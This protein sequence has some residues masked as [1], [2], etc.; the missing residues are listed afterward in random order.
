MIKEVISTLAL[1]IMPISVPVIAGV[2]L[3]RFMGMEIKALLTVVLYVLAPAMVFANLSTVQITFTEL[4]RVAM[5][6]AINATLMWAISFAAGKIL[7]LPD[8]GRA[9]LSLIATL[10]NA[11]NYG[12][13]LVQLAY[14]QA[15]LEKAAVLVVFMLIFTN[16]M[17]VY[18]A[19]RSNFSVRQ[20]IVAIFKL[21]AIYAVFLA[22]LLRFTGLSLPSGLNKG[23]NMLAGA[24]S[25]IMLTVLGAQMARVKNKALGGDRQLM[26]YSGLG[27]RML[28]SPV[29]AF[30]VLN[31]LRVE[32]ILFPVLLILAS[33]P[34]AVN[35]GVLAEN[36][37]AAP[38]VVSKCILWTTLSSFVALPVL[39]SLVSLI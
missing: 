37:D 4:S 16:T 29:V 35:A 12:L 10:T 6:F 15:G 21:P 36:F 23:V 14:G 20:A 30:F 9:G 25:P 19:A 31:I 5:F 27:L 38:D 2:L 32:G 11:V 22:L 28:V 17:G 13:P 3:T 39:I 34:V 18:F 7:R 8:A 1:V 26:F 33:M 24:H